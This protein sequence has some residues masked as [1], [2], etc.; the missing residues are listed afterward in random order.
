MM[1]A[2][3]GDGNGAGTTE[4]AAAEEA[5]DGDSGEM[6]GISVELSLPDPLQDE[7][8]AAQA[9]SDPEHDE[10]ALRDNV[11]RNCPAVVA[12]L[13]ARRTSAR[14]ARGGE[15][16][17]DESDKRASN[18]RVTREPSG[19][20]ARQ[21]A[22]LPPVKSRSRYASRSIW[23]MPVWVAGGKSKAGLPTAGFS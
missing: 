18:R 8:D 16:S 10:S 20:E 19:S 15:R 17:R 1:A 9:E 11:V 3:G 13:A 6:P 23:L 4:G 2:G 7:A 21:G 14:A 5:P 22:H 12:E